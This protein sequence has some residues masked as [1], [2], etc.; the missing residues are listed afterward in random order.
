M[1]LIP[2]G[3]HVEE[4]G[5]GAGLYLRLRSRGDLKQSRGLSKAWWEAE[6]RSVLSV[7]VLCT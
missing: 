2:P 3:M 6:V 4:V 1:T 7:S 5:P